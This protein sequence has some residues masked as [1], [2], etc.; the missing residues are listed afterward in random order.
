MRMCQGVPPSWYT[1]TMTVLNVGSVYNELG[2][3][4][5]D[6]AVRLTG[7]RTPAALRQRCLWLGVITAPSR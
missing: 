7:G 2:S 3:K 4:W 5:V 6:I 1:Y